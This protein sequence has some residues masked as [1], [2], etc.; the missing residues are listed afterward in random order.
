MKIS[1]LNIQMRRFVYYRD[2]L[3]ELVLRDIRVRYKR[4]IL[5]FAWSL[6]NPLLYL[7]VF[8]F[9]FQMAL[10]INIPR[11]GVFAFTGILVWSWF[12]TSLSQSTGAIVGSR[13]LVRTPGFPPAVL[14]VA[15]VTS[16]LIYF[17]VALSLL[18][19]FLLFFGNGL[20]YWV[21]MLP[22]LVFLQF[23]MTLGLAY[24]I[25][26]LNV[27]FR[28]IGHLVSVLLQLMFFL[29]P[30]FYDA[31][32]IPDDYQSLYRLNPMVHIIESYRSVLLETRAIS[33]WPLAIIAFCSSVM[34]FAGHR[35][36]MRLSYRFVE[37]L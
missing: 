32:M 25:A 3:R 31:S 11:F 24:L 34:L 4:S 33:L 15:I 26:A 30:I 35:I 19:V 29:T 17:L 10:A 9:V 12:Q 20:S 13:E 23:L 18:L 8:Y 16:N 27:L 22:V 1:L 14:P 7:T 28:D 5:G 2:L 6:A 21:M 37:E 36:F